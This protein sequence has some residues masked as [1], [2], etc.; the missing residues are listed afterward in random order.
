MQNPTFSVPRDHGVGER[1]P[2]LVAS[3]V[4]EVPVPVRNAELEAAGDPRVERGV[5]PA[6]EN[7]IGVGVAEEA[8]SAP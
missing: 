5:D 1:I 4:V 8:R 3:E 7:T 6:F 2:Q